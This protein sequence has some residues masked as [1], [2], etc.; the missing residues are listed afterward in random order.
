MTNIDSDVEAKKVNPSA[1]Y[2]HPEDVLKDTK[3]SREEKIAILREWHYDAMRLQ[4]S[5]G[6]NMTGGEPDRLSSVSKA[7]LKLGVS[8]SKEA[9]P[10]SEAKSSPMR[11]AQRYISNAMD[12][13]RPKGKESPK[14]K[15]S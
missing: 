5:A 12:A 10:K 4:E 9:D 14:S 13:L 6:E 11:K 7:L 8:P 1:A 15:E 3:L 2:N